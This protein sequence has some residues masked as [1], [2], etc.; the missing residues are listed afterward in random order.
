MSL[1]R[2]QD[3][4]CVYDRAHKDYLY[5]KNWTDKLIRELSDSEKFEQ[6]TR[7]PPKLK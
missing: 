2:N 5:T 4:Y 7:K 3:R 1:V 6:I